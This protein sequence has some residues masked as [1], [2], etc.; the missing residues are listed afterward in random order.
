MFDRE[1]INFIFGNLKS[2]NFP[3]Q[4]TN[5]GGVMVDIW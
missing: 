5:G 4:K 3:A 1:P 2:L